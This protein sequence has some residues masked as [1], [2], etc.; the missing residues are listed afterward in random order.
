MR[1]GRVRKA[2]RV[3]DAIHRFYLSRLQSACDQYLDSSVAILWELE[4]SC[5]DLCAVWRV[6]AWWQFVAQPGERIGARPL[7]RP[8]RCD[9]KHACRRRWIALDGDAHRGPGDFS[10]GQASALGRARIHEANQRGSA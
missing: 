3:R 9:S 7:S 10:G 5:S 1:A 2:A 8:E 6:S 4:M